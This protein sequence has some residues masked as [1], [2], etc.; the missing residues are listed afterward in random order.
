[1]KKKKKVAFFPPIF[2]EYFRLLFQQ[3]ISTAVLLI[4]TPIHPVF[5]MLTYSYSKAGIA[6]YVTTRV[7]FVIQMLHPEC[8]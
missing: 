4:K 3:T 2:K 5:F 1:M 8:W 7:A 6:A